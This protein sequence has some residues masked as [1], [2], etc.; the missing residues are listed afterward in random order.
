MKSPEKGE[1]SEKM[2]K[3]LISQI[4][5]GD[6]RTIRNIRD[7]AGEIGKEEDFDLTEI[8]NALNQGNSISLANL[9]QFI[10]R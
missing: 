3:M 9:K 10:G 4:I 8:W 7:R 6:L 2:V 1:M 5:E